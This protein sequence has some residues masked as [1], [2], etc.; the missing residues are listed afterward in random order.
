MET[1]VKYLSLFEYLGRPAGGSLGK[2]IY[3]KAKSRKIK[4]QS[5]DISNPKYSGKVMLYP[6]TFLDEY[7]KKEIINDDLPY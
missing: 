5:K 1:E 4:T 3:E 7:F 6:V 2:E